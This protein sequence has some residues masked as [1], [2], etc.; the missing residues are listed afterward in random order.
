MLVRWAIPVAGID[1]SRVE[2]H[3]LH[4]SACHLVDDNHWATPKPWSHRGLHVIDGMLAVELVTLTDEVGHRLLANTTAGTTLD[5]GN[6]VGTVVAPPVP[7]A[8]TPWQR[9]H[10][11]SA[12]TAWEVIFA[13]PSSFSSGSRFSPMPD[14][15]T[16]LR[17][18]T[19]RWNAVHPAADARIDEDKPLWRKSVWVSDIEGYSEA[20]RVSKAN[21][22]GFVGRVRYACDDADLAV[23][24]NRLLH[25]GEYAGV[26]R[27]TGHGLGQ[28]R[29]APTWSNT[30][31]EKRVVADGKRPTT[32]P[33]SA[34]D[35]LLGSVAKGPARSEGTRR[36][37][38]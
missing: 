32:R 1:P 17:S 35:S 26:G 24:M 27:Y 30:R 22:S 11:L 34:N 37:R 33:E 28:F 12:E 8:V 21:V 23:V 10:E 20:F 3:H 5:L 25:F 7:L 16:V 6:Q 18:L 13:T 29:L 19:Q 36:T 2:R 9:L 14:P 38:R 4:G 15:L 31:A